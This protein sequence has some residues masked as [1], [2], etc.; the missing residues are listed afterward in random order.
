[1]F[2]DSWRAGS[3]AVQLATIGSLLIL[4]FIWHAVHNWIP[5]PKHN[6]AAKKVFVFICF[7]SIDLLV[8]W[9]QSYIF[10]LNSILPFFLQSILFVQIELLSVRRAAVPPYLT[11]RLGEVVNRCLKCYDF[12]FATPAE[13]RFFSNKSMFGRKERICD[14]S[15]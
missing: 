5:R 13:N 2:D 15:C 9:R 4:L 1:M 10:L 11:M 14:E 3:T 12:F 6:S 7:Q 8:I